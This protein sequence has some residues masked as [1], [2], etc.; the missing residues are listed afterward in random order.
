MRVDEE[1]K[2]AG[3]MPVET[4]AVVDLEAIENLED[5][6]VAVVRPQKAGGKQHGLLLNFAKAPS[7]PSA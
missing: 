7:K 5:I 2:K 1:T 6:Q 3:T 4:A